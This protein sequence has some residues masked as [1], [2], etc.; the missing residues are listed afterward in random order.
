[1]TDMPIPSPDPAS[2]A[3]GTTVPPV[4]TRTAPADR[5]AGQK[6]M[7]VAFR[8]AGQD[9]CLDI[10]HVSEI[11]RRA[12][13]TRLPQSPAH[14]CGVFNLR[15]MV[16]PV[17]DLSLWLGLGAIPERDRNVIIIVRR[18]ARSVGL[19]VEEVSDILKADC[20]DLV[21]APPVAA[22]AEGAPVVSALLD[23]DAGLLRVLSA[24]LILPD[25]EPTAEAAP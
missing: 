18:G 20:A 8:A 4:T 21:A 14:V 22:G 13:T 15:G 9:F 12:E 1:M 5:Q 10:A 2:P 24:D 11:R 19:L 25:D 6:I 23:S 17:I 7:L 3:P 16:V